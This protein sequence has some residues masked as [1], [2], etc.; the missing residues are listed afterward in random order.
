[1][2]RRV[3]PDGRERL[4]RALHQQ[5]NAPTSAAESRVAELGFLARL[6]E[7][8]LQPPDRLPYVDRKVYSERRPREA[9]AAPSAQWLCER[10]GS[11]RRACFAAWGLLEDGRRRSGTYEPRLAPGRGRPARFTAEESVDA[12]RECA[13][14]LGYI[15]SSWDYHRWRL[16]R[17]RRAKAHGRDLRLPHYNAVIREL[18]PE[19]SKR[20]GWGIVVEKVF[21]TTRR[22]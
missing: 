10:F 1:M 12:V 11:W 7:E 2:L 18:A 21:G 6:L 17:V 15:P 22:P 4:A 8:E 19:R 14:A 9:P 3:D 5:L 16:A 20:E 13:N